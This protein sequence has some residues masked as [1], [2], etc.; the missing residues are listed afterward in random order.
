MYLG[1]LQGQEKGQK[2]RLLEGSM[3]EQFNDLSWCE[4]VYKAK[5]AIAIQPKQK[6]NEHLVI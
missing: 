6:A 5:S 1:F 4:E 3:K 2:L